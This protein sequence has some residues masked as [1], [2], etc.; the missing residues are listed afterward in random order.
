MNE[1]EWRSTLGS[2]GGVKTRA[3]IRHRPVLYRVSGTRLFESVTSYALVVFPEFGS[4]VGSH[5]VLERM[6]I[7]SRAPLAFGLRHRVRCRRRSLEMLTLPCV[8]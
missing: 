3:R 8:L 6:L 2:A 4:R 1:S 7:A 5:R